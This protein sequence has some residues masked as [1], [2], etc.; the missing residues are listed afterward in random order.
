MAFVTGHTEDA[1]SSMTEIRPVP[2]YPMYGVDRDGNTYKMTDGR[3]MPKR[4]TIS[5]V[6]YPVIALWA[7]NKGVTRTVH[8]L[9][10][11]VFVGPCPE[12]MEALHADGTRTNNKLENLRWGTRSE[13]MQ[14]AIAH[15]TSTAG[16]KNGG[17]RLTALDV[18]WIK[19]LFETG[20]TPKELLKHFK[21]SL[22]TIRR[23][24][25]GKTYKKEY[26]SG[27]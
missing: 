15:G 9:V 2:G 24:L 7:N 23:V 26:S 21:V 14:D 27:L 19:D 16:S 5:K 18:L 8:R 1:E 22:T 12:G 13:N 11:E 25:T 4:Q 20:F 17:A 3:W 6:G 10:L